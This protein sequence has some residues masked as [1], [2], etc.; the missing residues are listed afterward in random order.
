MKVINEN[1]VISRNEQQISEYRYATKHAPLLAG[2][3]YFIYGV[4]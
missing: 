3:S 4:W 2:V 1:I